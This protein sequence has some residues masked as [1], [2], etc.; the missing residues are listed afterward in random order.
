MAASTAH[1][2]G[3][4]PPRPAAVHGPRRHPL[5]A[6]GRLRAAAGPARTQAR[7]RSGGSPPWCRCRSRRGPGPCRRCT[8]VAVSITDA[9]APRIV[10][11]SNSRRAPPLSRWRR[12]CRRR[13][14]QN[15]AHQ[16]D[17]PEQVELLFDRE[18]PRVLSGDTGPAGGEVTACRSR[19]DARCRC[20]AASRA[21]RLRS[22]TASVGTNGESTAATTTSR[23]SR[24]QP[25]HAAHPEG[26]QRGRSGGC[27][28][29][30]RPAAM[31]SGS[32]RARRGLHAR[33]RHRPRHAA[34]VAHT[35]D[36][37][38]ARPSSP[39]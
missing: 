23:Q 3:G 27:S 19:S 17:R 31:W 14:S 8:G 35:A 24:Q 7:R 16:Q 15:L 6:A 34:V 36:R 11:A 21:R 1:Q 26:A 9:S 22:G 30:R 29:I 12:G 28:A 13:T 2:P 32:P 10:S 18:R 4:S 39:A 5:L 38:R 20:R 37:E 25:S 33:N